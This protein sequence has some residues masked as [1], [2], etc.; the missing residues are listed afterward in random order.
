[1]CTCTQWLFTMGHKDTKGRALVL[2]ARDNSLLP[3]RWALFTVP[4]AWRWVAWPGDQEAGSYLPLCIHHPIVSTVK[5]AAHSTTSNECPLIGWVGSSEV[6]G[7]ISLQGLS[8]IHSHIINIKR[9]LVP[10]PLFYLAGVTILAGRWKINCNKNRWLPVQKLV[11]YLHF[12]KNSTQI[13]SKIDKT[14]VF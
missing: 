5:I 10:P 2:L 14:M 13:K 3:E 4:G 9:A 7:P 11:K 1:M 12:S 6:S 8:F